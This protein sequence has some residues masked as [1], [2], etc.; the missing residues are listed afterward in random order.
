MGIGT[1]RKTKIIPRASTMPGIPILRKAT[2]SGRLLS[3]PS[4]VTSWKVKLVGVAGAVND[5]VAVVAPLSVT[6]GPAVCVH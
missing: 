2:V 4:L 6:A 1:V 3:A 5:S